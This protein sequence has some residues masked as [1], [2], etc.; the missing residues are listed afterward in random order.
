MHR[1]L[2]RFSFASFVVGALVLSFPCNTAVSLDP[3]VCAT[4]PTDANPRR[5]SGRAAA[6]DSRPWIVLVWVTCEGDEVDSLR[7]CE[8]ALIRRQWVLTAANCFLCGSAA[9]VVA[10]VGLHNS[11]IRAE[12]RYN[13]SVERIG[14]D[15]IF[16]PPGFKYLS[17]K[18]DVALLHLSREVKNATRVIPLVDCSGGRV[19]NRRVGVSSGWGKIPSKARLDPKPLQD[20]YI[21]VWPSDECAQMLGGD[22]DGMLCAGSMEHVV[23]NVSQGE[24]FGDHSRSVDDPCFVEWGSPLVLKEPKVVDDASG[25]GLVCEWKLLGVLSFGLHCSM[26]EAE[27]VPGFYTSV[28]EYRSWIE[29]TIRKENGKTGCQS[30]GQDMIL[31][32]VCLEN[33]V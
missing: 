17:A 6:P 11:D 13:R 14:V 18:G 32:A 1:S 4:Y 5:I 7:T 15:G 26:D 24:G 9:A 22:R 23:A 30:C 20:A 12:I 31:H 21:A 8:G 25:A 29:D 19:D 28:C 27:E 33:C 10:D 3:A 16:I 2:L